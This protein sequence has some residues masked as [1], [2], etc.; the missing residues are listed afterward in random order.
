[1]RGVLVL[2]ELL[3]G[4]NALGGGLYGLGGMGQVP[5]EVLHGTPF[6]SPLVPSLVL[7]VVVGGSQWLAAGLLLAR[8]R[9]GPAASVAAGLVLVGWNVAQLALGGG[10]TLLQP[11]MLVA[12]VVIAAL[13]LVLRR[14]PAAQGGA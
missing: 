4:L 10:A 9:R 11:L 12:G 1:V 5:L 14:R 6:A 13:G 3:V 7:L 2:I 8:H